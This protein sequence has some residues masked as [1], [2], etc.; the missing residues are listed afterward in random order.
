MSK[1]AHIR[2][3]VLSQARYLSGVRALVAAVAERYGF[4]Q[5]ACS[6]IA[7]AVDEALA[8]VINHGYKRQPTGKIWV[9]ISP[10]E[11]GKDVRGVTIVIEDEAKQVDVTQIQSRSLDD[12]RPGGLG[13]HIIRELMDSAVWELRSEGGMRLTILKTRTGGCG[14]ASTNP[15]EKG[16]HG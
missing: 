4:D 14:D 15:D 3:E 12:V 1:T 7:L 9:S 16:G 8:N 6:Q 11:D 2:M 5:C 13:V 10:I